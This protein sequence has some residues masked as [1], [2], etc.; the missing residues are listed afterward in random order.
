MVELSVVIPTRDRPGPLARCLTALDGQLRRDGTVEVLV[1]DDGSAVDPTPV[2]A[3]ACPSAR[4]IRQAHGGPGAA[5]NRGAAA[6]SGLVL[7][8]LDDD[9][10]PGEGLLEA[11]LG[12]HR[13]ADELVVLGRLDWSGPRPGGPFA[14]QQREAWQAHHD[15]L[16]S[17]EGPHPTDC[18]AGNLSLPAAVFRRLGGFAEDLGRSE[19]VELGY[20]LSEAGCRFRY[21]PA[22]VAVQRTMKGF[23]GF[24]ADAAAAGRAAVT[25]YRRHPP[26]IDQLPLGRYAQARLRERVLRRATLAVPGGLALMV[27][28]E[29]L[30]AHGP[31]RRGWYGFAWRTAYWTG[32]RTALGRTDDWGRLVE[33]TTVL[34][35][36]AFARAGEPA[37]RWVIPL[38][39]LDRQVRWLR[40]RGSR[41]L[42]LEDYLELR[43]RHELPPPRSVVVTIDDGYAGTEE[44]LRSLA[45]A[46]VP[47]T[48][49][50]VS[51]RVGGNNTWDRRGPLAGRP[52]LDWP[53]ILELEAAGTRFGAHS[54]T[55]RHPAELSAAEA[56]VEV[57]GARQA[58]ESRLL[59]RITA[60]AYPYG[61]VSP[62]LEAATARAGFLG[63]LAVGSRA[64]AAGEPLL[65]LRRIP[66]RGTDSLLRF[67]LTIAS[68]DAAW[69]GRLL[70]QPRTARPARRR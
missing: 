18:Y 6:A 52:L 25:L 28:L 43:V 11:H 54:R 30:V 65:R 1:V 27:G 29:P 35:Y 37:S 55:H 40:R 59:R 13:G 8:F 15:R 23:A 62:E 4:L 69:L 9:M 67:V 22:A 20:R 48:V 53:A 56:E 60:F 66:V 14:R 2:V 47:A 58:L 10:V 33:G 17:G 5:R 26:A 16:A 45:Q 24:L 42:G 3:A 63:G 64:N 12:A 34:V 32:V 39:G 68:G 7:L 46:G 50:L 36:H 44:G 51:D 21:E 70:G 31:W 61:E 57:A 49:F 38:Q 19:D 41:F